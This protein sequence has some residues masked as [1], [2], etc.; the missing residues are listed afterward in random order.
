MFVSV[1]L[2]SMYL[3]ILSI[4]ER[5]ILLPS[6][7]YFVSEKVLTFLSLYFRIDV[8]STLLT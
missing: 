4:R 8:F 2:V 3:I 7:N 5:S 1:S 6:L